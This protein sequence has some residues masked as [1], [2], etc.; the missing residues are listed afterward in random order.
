MPVSVLAGRLCDAGCARGQP[1]VR[2]QHAL[3]AIT[4]AELAVLC[5]AV[6]R[7]AKKMVMPSGL[8]LPRFD[9]QLD[10]RYLEAQR[11]CLTH[12]LDLICNRFSHLM[13]RNLRRQQEACDF[14][15]K[16]AGCM[17]A[18]LTARKQCK[19]IY[20]NELCEGG[21]LA[22]CTTSLCF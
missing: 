10:E 19:Q 14:T 13:K 12:V 15:D 6:N 4:S 16:P 7:L 11:T 22:L 17:E 5:D 1:V 9:R 8:R 21:T 2:G 18:F 20:K 3:A